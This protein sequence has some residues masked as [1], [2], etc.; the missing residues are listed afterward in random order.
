RQADRRRLPTVTIPTTLF[1]CPH[2]PARGP[3]GR[4]ADQ[5]HR[6]DMLEA[7]SKDDELL[8]NIQARWAELAKLLD[9]INAHW[10]YEDLIYRFYHQS[11]KVYAL[12]RETTRIVAAL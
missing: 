9:D 4:I 11:F 2:E 6:W 8:A 7:P 3:M 12:Q 10:V 5:G 1:P